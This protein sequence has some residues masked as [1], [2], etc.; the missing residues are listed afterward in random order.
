MIKTS[1]ITDE[2]S[3]DFEEAAQ[4]ASAFKL[5]ALELRTLWDKAFHELDEDDIAQVQAICKQHSLPICAISSPFYKCGLTQPEIQQHLAILEQTIARAKQLNCKI[6]RGFSFWREGN[7]EEQLPF[8][9]EAF[10][11]PAQMV[12]EAGMTLA[13]ELDPSVNACNGELLAKV[14]KEINHPAVTVLWD[15]GNDLYSPLP[16][17]PFPQGYQHVKSHI[18]HVH[19]K[20]AVHKNGEA[21]SVKIGTGS[22]DWPAQLE[23]LVQ[24][25]Y[26]GYASLEPHYRTNSV[27][28][29]SL[30]RNPGGAAFSQNGMDTGI[31]CII[32]LQAMLGEITG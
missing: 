9:A 4:I 31:E 23:A 1:I 15:P 3:Q 26:T 22:V 2:I 25:G 7:F 19:I 6:I 24:N 32:A 29:E 14:V 11:L 10:A 30:M 5:D 21:E 13:L 20:D 17:R 18:S 28:S 27:I 8:I 16:E 12:Q